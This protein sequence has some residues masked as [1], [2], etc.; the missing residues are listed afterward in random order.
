M[1]QRVSSEFVVNSSSDFL[2]SSPDIG[3]DSQGDSVIVWQRFNLEDSSD[4]GIYFRRFDNEADDIDDDD[5]TV[6]VVSDGSRQS[7]PSIGVAADGRFVVIWEQFLESESGVATEI[8]VR[9]YESD[10]DAAGSEFVISDEDSPSSFTPDIAINPLTAGFVATWVELDEDGDRNILA[11]RFDA[12]GDEDGDVIVVETIDEDDLQDGQ[13]LADPVIALDPAGRF[14]I[15]WIQNKNENNDN[16]N[17]VFAKRFDSSGA[18]LN[19]TFV[20]NTQQENGQFDPDIAVDSSG[21][22]TIVW[23]SAFVDNAGSADDNAGIYGRRYDDNGVALNDAFAVAAPD[24]DDGSA[25]NA[26]IAMDDSGNTFITWTNFSVDDIDD[27]TDIFV[28]QYDSTGNGDTPIRVN[29]DEISGGQTQSALAVTSAG[30]A[31]AVWQG[32]PLQSNDDFP[33]D[34]DIL[35]QRLS[36]GTSSSG[37]SSGGSGTEEEEEAPEAI[38]LGSNGGDVLE[39]TG[40]AEIIQGFGGN[41]EIS[42]KQGDDDI[43]GG[44]GKDRINGDGGADQLFGDNG[45]DVIRG[46]A[47]DDEIFGGNGGDRLQG[48]KDADTIN[49]NNGRD[50]LFGNEGDDLLRG[51][52]GRDELRG[53]VDNDCLNGGDGRDILRGGQGDDI[54]NGGKGNDELFGGAGA[55]TFA[56][57]T[58]NG[59][60]V[61]HGFNAFQDSLGFASLGTGLNADFVRVKKGTV[62]KINGNRIALVRGVDLSINASTLGVITA[63]TPGQIFCDPALDEVAEEG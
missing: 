46:N 29:D 57:L 56:V 31:V 25:S 39:G 43:F 40:E 30:D 32:P 17:D 19:D 42:G 44:D 7:S 33:S 26:A 15:A 59:F 13:T 2:E 10:G 41:D 36:P 27:G 62:I 60:D 51:G 5:T 4:R 55:D 6:D 49:G 11:Q 54:L 21:N 24:S 8:A 53:N 48:D 52:L 50:R 3:I 18:I 63:M 1:A 37:G 34:Q 22:F 14:T 20:V 61:I 47:G 16:F 35:G 45:N 12:D 28:R 58:R 23:S 38:Q 9:L